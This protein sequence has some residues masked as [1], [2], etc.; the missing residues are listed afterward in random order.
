MCDNKESAGRSKDV[1]RQKTI[2]WFIRTM[3]HEGIARCLE[4]WLQVELTE[5]SSTHRRS[6][7]SVLER[8]DA[9]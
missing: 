2:R 5:A 3:H 6:D 7:R 1:T 4:F 9:T 8:L